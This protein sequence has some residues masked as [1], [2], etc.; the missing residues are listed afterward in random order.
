M[1]E[2]LHE[3]HEAIDIDGDRKFTR[4]FGLLKPR[5]EQVASEGLAPEDLVADGPRLIT[6][7][8][9]R[10]VMRQPRGSSAANCVRSVPRRSASKTPRAVGDWN[11][12]IT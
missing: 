5:G 6:P 8:H 1:H 12:S 4:A 10:G 7:L 11:A 9:R 2:A 3:A